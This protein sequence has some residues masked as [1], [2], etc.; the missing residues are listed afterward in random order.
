MFYAFKLNREASLFL[1][2]HFDLH[3]R[4]NLNFLTV[5][6]TVEGLPGYGFGMGKNLA[7]EIGVEE[8]KVS[9]VTFLH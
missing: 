7:F 1:M 2:S 8:A 6:D 5:Y 9:R 4:V 3:R